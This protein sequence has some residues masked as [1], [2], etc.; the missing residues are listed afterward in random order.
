MT[1]LFELSGTKRGGA[2]LNAV[3]QVVAKE[4]RP[5]PETVHAELPEAMFPGFNADPPAQDEIDAAMAMI[6]AQAAEHVASLEADAPAE[7]QAEPQAETSDKPEIHPTLSAS[8]AVENLRLAHV[9]LAEARAAVLTATNRRAKCREVLSLAVTAWQT[10][11]PRMSREQA[12]RE[13]IATYQETRAEQHRQTTPGPSLVD[14]ISAAQRGGPAA[15]GNFRRG[16]YTTR[17]GKNYDPRRGPVAK[18]PS[19][20]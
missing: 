9:A 7:Q 19:Q 15:Y 8:E 2:I 16:A 18:L 5:T 13:V 20:V 10:N 1:S 3:H 11:M 17:G 14:R 6:E 4:L 12:A